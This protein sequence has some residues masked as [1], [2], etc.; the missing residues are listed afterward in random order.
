MQLLVGQMIEKPIEQLTEYVNQQIIDNPALEA[1]PNEDG[2]GMK[3]PPTSKTKTVT[4]T[5]TTMQ[6]TMMT[7]FPSSLKVLGKTL[8]TQYRFTTN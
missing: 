1:K 7:I 2:N 5:P 8:P 3:R 6:E 4:L